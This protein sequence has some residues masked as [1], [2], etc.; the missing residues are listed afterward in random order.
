MARDDFR[1]VYYT[2]QVDGRK[3]RTS[4]SI[5]PD[6]YEIFSMVSGGD[7]AADITLKTW[8]MEIESDREEAS[9]EGIGASRLVARRVFGRIKELVAAGLVVTQAEQRKTKSR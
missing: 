3:K 6:L 9:F 1:R 7:V 5:D 2:K 8:A 4:V